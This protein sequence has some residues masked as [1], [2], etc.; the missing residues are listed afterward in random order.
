MVLLLLACV[1]D[2]DTAKKPVRPHPTADT[3]TAIPEDSAC[4]FTASIT[5]DTP[6]GVL[7][8]TAGLGVDATCAPGEWTATWDF[9]D[10][11]T[12]TGATTEHTWLA[13]GDYTVS[14]ALTAGSGSAEADTRIR[15]EAPDCP[16]TTTPE[17]V[18]TLQNAALV[19]AS[20][21]AQTA[22]GLLW[23][24][25]DSGDIA[26]LFA[27]DEDGTDRG[28]FPLAGAP[29]GDW[30][31]LAQ[32]GDTLYVGDIGQ[33]GGARPTS[34]IYVVPEPSGE[35]TWTSFELVF[36]DGDALD[37]NTMM[38]DPVTGDL[39]LIA[40][41]LDGTWAVYRGAA[42]FADGDLVPLTKV[43][44]LALPA[45]PTGGAFSPLGDKLAVRTLDQAWVLLRDQAEA[46]DTTWATTPCEIPLGDEPAG[47][48]ITLTDEGYYTTGEA[49]NHPIYH[50]S[51]VPP[52]D[53]CGDLIELSDDSYEIPFSPTFSIN[54]AC[55]LAGVDTVTWDYGDGPTTDTTYTWLASGTYTVSAEVVD[56]DGVTWTDSVSFG[57]GGADCPTPGATQTWGTIASE[58]IIEA[59]GLAQSMLEDGVYWTHNDSGDEP[60]LFAIGADGADLGTFSVDTDNADW[61]DIA[62]GW[63]ATLGAPA[64]YVG[65]FGDNGEDRDHVAVLVVPE[66]S[67]DLTNPVDE[68]VPEFSTL[69]LLYPDGAHNAETLMV[70]PVTGDLYVVTKATDGASMVFRKPAPHVDGT[71]TEL[72]LVA[73]L[74]FG[75]DPLPGSA[76]ATGGAF[77]ALGD[78]IAIRTYDH[79]FLWRRD[80]SFS[81]AHAF[82]DTPCDLAAPTEAQGEAITFTRD[83]A[84]YL[85]LSEGSAEPLYFTPLD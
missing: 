13:S 38:V 31:D 45:A 16:A 29:D 12:A 57:V 48:A 74:Q 55:I 85:T 11:T 65:D 50:T 28:Q 36:P 61:E 70:D 30:E 73:N 79:A 42:P 1:D 64:I 43:T 54:D 66:P 78:R 60:R 25:N 77:S 83:G 68:D 81:V 15:V 51:F 63:D 52:E 76:R 37:S 21:L 56:N 23:S 26:Q 46:M 53:P 27:F 14:V 59:S 71:E 3:D 84:G 20:G 2:A 33:N 8:F 62:L 10:G 39:Y 4:T 32:D 82:A 75:A 18:G 9:G 35:A 44:P 49:L 41:E 69:T 24:H 22:D 47:E 6:V 17:E 40:N 80:Q 72:E 34:T 67:V 58:D 7:P 5:T 19:E